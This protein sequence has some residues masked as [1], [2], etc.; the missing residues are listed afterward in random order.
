[1]KPKVSTNVPMLDGDPY[2]VHQDMRTLLEANEI[3][4]DPKRLKAALGHAKKKA[5]QMTSL[6]A[7][8]QSPQQ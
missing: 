1:M 8:G 4:K 2:D 6:Q 3:R 7:Q 5:A